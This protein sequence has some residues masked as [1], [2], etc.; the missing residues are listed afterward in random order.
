MKQ[1][2]FEYNLKNKI[3]P[4]AQNILTSSKIHAPTIFTYDSDG[5]ERIAE[6]VK[7]F[8]YEDKELI[9]GI[10]S[11]YL[12]ESKSQAF[13]LI[14]DDFISK[15]IEDKVIKEKHYCLV[16]QYQYKNNYGDKRVALSG[17]ISY[18]YE[19]IEDNIIID[20]H[21]P[22]VFKDGVD[23]SKSRLDNIF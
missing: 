16:F 3:I 18:E 21:N 14:N 11:K 5:V 6:L 8:S 4:I 19:K 20:Y 15:Y 9:Y 17:T 23:K 10:I 22:N 1:K 12:I 2:T 7:L 13:I